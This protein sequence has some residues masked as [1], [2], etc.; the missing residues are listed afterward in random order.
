MFGTPQPLKQALSNSGIYSSFTHNFVQDQV[1]TDTSQIPL[2]QPEIQAAIQKAFPPTLLEQNSNKIID[3]TYDWVQGR[4]D[5]PDFA[6][7]LSDAKNNLANYIADYVRTRSA[8][9]PVCNYAQLSE[10]G[11]ISNIDPYK[12]TCRPGQI[13]PDAIAEQAKQDVLTSDFL[14][15][16]ELTA[17]TI[18]SS[19][20]KTLQEQLKVV[21]EAYKWT[22]YTMYATGATA[23]LAM[24]IIIALQRN[25]IR[26]ACKHFGRILLTIGTISAAI[27]WLTSFAIDKVSHILAE[28][29]TS[30]TLQ[31]KI[32]AIFG[33]LAHDM[34]KWWIGY[35]VV[36]IIL[37]IAALVVRKFVAAPQPATAG[38]G[39]TGLPQNS[40]PTNNEVQL[41]LG[42]TPPF[43]ATPP[44]V[45]EKRDE[46]RL[47]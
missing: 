23:V 29:A 39:E 9:L 43:T 34:Q 32:V 46:T 18:K 5:S 24:V 12:A 19:D 22:I 8:A 25:H 17:S 1:A 10:L 7:N 31:A 15:N 16:P 11:S 40:M 45:E 42:G 28:N 21:P 30:T 13:S 47:Q 14:N 26:N 27:A 4:S 33:S 41:P 36:L 35:G 2:Q 37:G 3:G 6:V 44:A 20:G 38:V